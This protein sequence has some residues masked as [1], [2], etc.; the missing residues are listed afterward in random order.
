MRPFLPAIAVFLLAGCFAAPRQQPVRD[1][2]RVHRGDFANDLLLTG[3]LTAAQGAMISVPRLPQWQT[4]IKW[5]ATE[6]TEVKEGDR[7]AELDNTQFTTALETKRQAVV[8]ARQELAQKEAE[9]SADLAQKVL[10]ADKKKVDYDKTK[11]DAAVPQEIVSGR[12]YDDRQIKFKRATVEYEK[13]AAVLRS[14]REGVGADRANLL[15]ALAKAERELHDADTAIAALTLRAPRA[16]VV[17]V[18]EHPW[19][20]R[21]LQ[22]GDPAWV[23]LPLAMIPD[24]ASLEVDAAL[25]DVDDGRLAVGMPATVI[26]DAY[27]ALRFTGKVVQISAVAQ[28]SARLSLRR[29]FGVK[30][31]LDSID[32]ARMRPGLSARVIVRRNTQRN[33]LLVPRSALSFGGKTPRAHLSEGTFS[34]VSLGDCNA[35]QCIVL[36]GLKD[37]DRL[38]PFVATEVARD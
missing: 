17:V 35:Q 25:A 27:P 7:V 21:K 30:V 2:L 15:V 38:A 1:D 29:A 28:E 31:A 5:L 33:V 9:W 37:G 6:G 32:R 10:D 11:L 12:E 24:I 36:N 34:D 26:L 22:E 16:G 8:Q 14:A 13:A 18:R 3:E 4:S 23:G 19:E 20:G